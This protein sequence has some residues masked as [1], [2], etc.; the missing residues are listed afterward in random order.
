MRIRAA[1]VLFSLFF[2]ATL[3]AWAQ[4][5]T[6]P[7]VV[8]VSPSGTGADYTTLQ[9]ALSAISDASAG[10]PYV[11]LAYP[12]IYTGTSNTSLRWKSYVSLRGVDRYSTII[13]GSVSAPFY[14]TPLIDASSLQGIEISNITLDGTAQFSA[15]SG[16]LGAG[17]TNVCGAQVTFTDVTYLQ[18]GTAIAIDSSRDHALISCTAPGNVVVRNCDTGIVGDFGGDWL[19]SGSWLHTS[20]AAAGETGI[21][22]VRSADVGATWGGTTTITGSV[23][24]STGTGTSLADVYPVYIAPTVEPGE[25]RIIGST[26]IARS[27][28]QAPA[29]DVAPIFP[30]GSGGTMIIEG[31]T[32]I[33]ES[34]PNA[35]GGE[36]YGINAEVSA[37]YPT[38]VRNSMIR[39]IGSGGTRADVRRDNNTIP[40][41]LA[42][43]DYS[44]VT[45]TGA[46][47]IATS[48]FRQGQFSA[49][50]TIPLTTPTST[51]NGRLYV[52][53][54]DRL[55][56]RSGGEARCV[57]GGF[58][59]KV[60]KLGSSSAPGNLLCVTAGTKRQGRALVT[61]VSRDSGVAVAGATITGNWSGATTQNGVTAVTDG[62]G[63]AT[64]TSNQVNPGGVFTF[65]VTNVALPPN[66]YDA[67][68]NLETTD[69]TPVCN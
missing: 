58:F 35:T 17:A 68:A 56:Y 52:G 18:D 39:S 19:I 66:F 53:T 2:A 69:S 26:V 24:E 12:G 28:V 23:L 51:S 6:N 27:T 50:L 59:M 38:L 67:A 42:G 22:Y 46:S 34:V 32:L 45:G 62:T 15:S 44:T 14:G 40:I 33:Y 21:A 11:I 37:A 9:A 64:F 36:Y 5:V 1:L 4:P 63:T 20:T 30:N 31:S 47:G 61:V 29:Y 16:A 60:S 8:T 55:C 49:D 65:A 3:T 25:L 54:S 48:D 7:K 41:S 57:G 43:V 10:N 13:R